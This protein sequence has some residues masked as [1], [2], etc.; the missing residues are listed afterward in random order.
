MRYVISGPGR[1]D[2]PWHVDAPTWLDALAAVPAL[3]RRRYHYEPS[4]KPCARVV[5]GCMIIAYY[6]GTRRRPGL[7]N[8]GVLR[9]TALPPMLVTGAPDYAAP[10]PTTAEE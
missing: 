3:R 1:S 7:R 9:V 4:V 6:R 2:G 10:T 8:A 5:P